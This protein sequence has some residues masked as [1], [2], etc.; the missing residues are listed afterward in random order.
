MKTRF[1]QL[2]KAIPFFCCLLTLSFTAQG[3]QAQS[4]PIWTD[5]ALSAEQAAQVEATSFRALELDESALRD[6]P[7]K[8]HPSS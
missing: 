1:P 6:T 5:N 4:L 2:Q 7:E 8:M 3:L